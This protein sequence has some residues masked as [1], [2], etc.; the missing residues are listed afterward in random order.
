VRRSDLDS[1]RSSRES[2]IDLD[3]LERLRSNAHFSTDYTG[4][5]ITTAH[6]D[7]DAIPNDEAEE[8]EVAFRLFAPTSS[9][10]KEGTTQIIRLRSPTPMDLEPGLVN[11]VRDRSYFFTG[12]TSSDLAEEY[13]IAAVSGEDVRARSQ[14]YW[15]GSAYAWK[16]LSIPRSQAMAT[17]DQQQSFKKLLGSDASSK[18]RVRLGKK[19]RIRKRQKL[20]ARKSKAEEEAHAKEEKDRLEREKRARRNREKKNKKRARDKAKKT[21]GN[22]VGGIEDG[23]SAAGIVEEGDISEG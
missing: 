5:D 10:T 20:A 2:S 18:R 17:L 8:E 1:P 7:D 16:V 13:A 21:N 12:D 23:G 4:P 11:P 15:P 6:R 14:S 3:A 22:T 9:N 19:A